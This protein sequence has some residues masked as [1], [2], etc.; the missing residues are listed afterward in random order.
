M[1][2]IKNII[3]GVLIL[4]T[5]FFVYDMI[6]RNKEAIKIPVKILVPV[7][8]KEG[9]S[10]TIYKPLPIKIITKENPLN[11]ELSSSNKKLLLENII[12]L[13]KYKKADSIA[14]AKQYQDAI[15]IKE[16]NQEYKDTFQ[17]VNV[18]SKTR[19][20]LLEQAITYKTEK[21]YI[22]LDTTIATTIKGKFKVLGQM[23]I[24]SN[25]IGKETF[26]KVVAKPSIIFQNSKDNGLS[27]SIDT[28]GIGYLGVIIKF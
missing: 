13:E 18:Y 17:T 15:S 22:P 19:G 21:Y 24:G 16:Y 25:V 9:T 8:S 4:V 23:E 5:A 12:L 27:L 14:K 2:S 1:K 28:Q 3:I 11:Q 7:P 10:D 20:E 6:T 26:T